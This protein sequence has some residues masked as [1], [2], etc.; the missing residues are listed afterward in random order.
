MKHIIFTTMLFMTSSVFAATGSLWCSLS[1]YGTPTETLH[2]GATPFALIQVDQTQ[3]G[4]IQ[5]DIEDLYQS[6][7]DVFTATLNH[8]TGHKISGIDIGSYLG[9]KEVEIKIDNGRIIL[10]VNAVVFYCE[11]PGNYKSDYSKDVR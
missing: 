6:T 7:E 4:S 10:T 11:I 5:L 8:S 9:E 1:S 2:K 3:S